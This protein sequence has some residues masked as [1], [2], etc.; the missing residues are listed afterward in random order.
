MAKPLS[1]LRELLRK[2]SIVQETASCTRALAN[3]VGT[4]PVQEWM[5][6]AQIS[7]AMLTAKIWESQINVPMPRSLAKQLDPEDAVFL[8]PRN[9]LAPLF[10][11]EYTL[12]GLPHKEGWAEVD[13]WGW[14]AP[15]EWPLITVWFSDGEQQFCAGKLPLSQKKAHISQKRTD[16]GHGIETSMWT[17]KLHLQIFHWPLVLDDNRLSWSVV[18]RVK[19]LQ[20]CSASIALVIR[21]M[22]LEGAHPI[23]DIQRDDKGNWNVHGKKFL[24]LAQ[25]GQTVM[26]SVHGQPDIWKTFAHK[27]HKNVANWKVPQK[28]HIHCPAGQCSVAEMYH[29]KLEKQE[30]LS[31]FAIVLPPS[32]FQNWQHRDPMN[33]WKG[34]IAERQILRNI[35]SGLQISKHQSLLDKVEQRLLLGESQLSLAGCLSTIALARLGFVRIA[36]ERLSK[37]LHDLDLE[38][39]AQNELAAILV[40]TCAEYGLWT[41]EKSWVQEHREIWGNILSVLSRQRVAPGG[42]ELFGR[43][44]SAK[45][46]E[47]WRVAALL[48]GTRVLRGVDEEHKRWGLAGAAAHEQLANFLGKGPWAIREEQSAD[49]A[50]AGLLAAGWLGLLPVDHPELVRTEQF[51]MNEMLHADG[52]LLQGGANI[53]I[54]GLMFAVQ[55][56]QDPSKDVVSLIANFASGTSSLPAVYHRTRGALVDGDSLL[57]ASIFAL[58]IL[59]DIL[60]QREK[61]TLGGLIQQAKDLPTPFGRIDI[62]DG[63][64]VQKLG[65]PIEYL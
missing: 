17:E 64:I 27:I 37:W 14:F 10:A 57:S 21:P 45:W 33:F 61:I 53:P 12:L 47:I 41:K 49:G 2:K 35:G 36:G 26:H 1:R 65:I 56:R 54:T 52:V 13:P 44:G 31:A 22:E 8:P 63:K 59:D 43:E 28:T 11:K 4:V 23:F 46:S 58:L 20:P 7:Q 19:A 38:Q 30:I 55:K 39:V 6:T 24:A 48:N 15:K 34:A 60:V 42:T 25:P 5:E 32:N 16:D 62:F 50:S 40:W 9:V 18:A 3:L 29:K 51:V